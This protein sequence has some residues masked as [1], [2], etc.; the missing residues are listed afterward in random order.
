MFIIIFIL[1]VTKSV[2]SSY[3]TITW[4]TGLSCRHVVLRDLGA[5]S[6]P[7]LAVNQ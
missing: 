3:D 5:V 6:L 1:G 2:I 7:K 4:F